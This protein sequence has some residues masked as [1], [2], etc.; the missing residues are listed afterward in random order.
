VYVL[1]STLVLLAIVVSACG[2][3]G[4]FGGNTVEISMVYGSEKEE[5]LVPLVDEFNQAK[6]KTESGA[7]IVVE[8]TPMGSVSSADAIVAETIQ[9]TIWSPASDLYVPVANANWRKGHTADLVDST[10][11]YLVLSPV[12]VAMWQPMAEALGWPNT[13]I[14]WS[15]ISAMSVSE[16]GWAA[17]GYPEWGSFKFGHTHPNFSNSGLVATIAQAY[18]GAQKQRGLTIEDLKDPAVQE[19]MADVQNSIIHYGESTGFFANRMFERGPS[20]LSA[21]VMY[22]NLIVAQESKRLSGEVPQLP[23]VAV[24]PKEGTFWSNHP[25]AILNAP[26]VTEEQHEAAEIFEAFLLDRPQQERAI[27]YGFR[28]SDPAIPLSFPLDAQ[29]GVDINQ[30]ATVLE[31]PSAEVIIGVQELWSQVKKPVDVVVVMDVS[32]SMQGNKISAARD[33]LIDF[34]ELLDDRDRLQIVLFNMV[35]IDLTPLSPVGEKRQDT[36]RRVSGIIEEGGTRLY[37]GT[38]NAYEQIEQQADP[39]HIRAVIVLSDGMDTDSG[40]SL[41]QLL[42]R[43]G[44]TGEESGRS[45]KIFTIAFGEDADEDVLRRI[46]E[47]TGGRMFKGDPQSIREIYEEIETFF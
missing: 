33:S 37:D 18:A 5:W 10:L 13:P 23:V 11:N 40:T 8:A 46:A 27:Q 35:L 4:I 26:W 15:D 39:Q 30:P 1:I 34:I 41:D 24:Y 45:I 17:F 20:Y 42:I 7:T 29:H 2:S 12:V 22:E 25:Y 6:N 14:G 16:E 9:P 28:P 3:A 44:A 36:I 32:G 43:I 47:A 21:A 31:V 38:L 19:F